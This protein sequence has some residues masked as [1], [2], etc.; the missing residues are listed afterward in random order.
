MSERFEKA[1]YVMFNDITL[2]RIPVLAH[3]RELQ[4]AYWYQVVVRV[5]RAFSLHACLTRTTRWTIAPCSA[6]SRNAQ[7]SHTVKCA[8]R[9]D[10]LKQQIELLRVQVD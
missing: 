4:Y 7:E 10:E 5:S 2:W 6:C 1:K 9:W 8:N 3:H